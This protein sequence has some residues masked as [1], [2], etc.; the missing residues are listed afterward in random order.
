LS[1]R[2]IMDKAVIRVLPVDIQL[3]DQNQRRFFWKQNLR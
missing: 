3:V 2:N 1:Q